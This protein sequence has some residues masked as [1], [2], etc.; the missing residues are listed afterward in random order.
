MI[1][2]N[3][4]AGK[5]AYSAIFTNKLDNLMY[6]ECK[7]QRINIDFINDFHRF[8][9]TDTDKKF[10]IHKIQDDKKN[11]HDTAINSMYK[12]TDNI[13]FEIEGVINAGGTGGKIFFIKNRTSNKTYVLKS[14]KL[15]HSIEQIQDYLSLE[16]VR[17]SKDG[18]GSIIGQ[19]NYIHISKDAYDEYDKSDKTA[20]N[21]FE[22]NTQ[23]TF[24]ISD[25]PTKLLIGC[26]N[27]DFYND[28]IINLILRKIY[29]H[30]K[31]NLST[32]EYPFVLYHNFYISYI[33]NEL[34]GFVLM[35]K[36][37]GN[38]MNY[39]SNNSLIVNVHI[40]FE[41]IK[42]FLCITKH[43]KYEFT[44]TDLKL[45]NIFYKEVNGRPLFYVA[46]F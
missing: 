29:S 26:P 3:K 38:A 2:S 24:T 5:D 1:L 44:H 34:S 36:M 42:E 9:Y 6:Y 14:Y 18:G 30:H 10:V 25:D 13:D 8:V 15:G 22:T 27:G 4:D 41:Q 37:D 35:D 32:D 39:I 11:P 28:I 40:L 17:I 23:G 43:S 33:D 46:D 12:F 19:N 7:S 31:P 20:A 16:F 21:V 45:E